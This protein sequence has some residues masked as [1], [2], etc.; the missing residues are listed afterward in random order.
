M[1]ETQIHNSFAHVVILAM[2]LDL[3]RLQI[4]V[5]LIH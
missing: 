4:T 5:M 3:R 1:S 2:C